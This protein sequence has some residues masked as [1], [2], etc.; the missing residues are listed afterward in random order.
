[1]TRRKYISAMKRKAIILI[2][3]LSIAFLGKINAQE[4]RYGILAGGIFANQKIETEG[5]DIL[6][7][8]YDTQSRFSWELGMM[9]EVPISDG[10]TVQPTLLLSNKGYVYKDSRDD[11]ELTIKSRPVYLSLPIPICGHIMLDDLKFIA[12][13]GPY[14][15]IGLGGKIDSTGN[16]GNFSFA[17]DG[18]IDYGDDDSDDYRP[19][20]LGIVFTGGI[21]IQEFQL[22]LAYELGLKNIAPNGDEDTV[23][24][25]RSLS[26]RGVYF[27]PF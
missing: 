19:L 12:G 9:A 16:S 11:F 10:L 8:D 1:M 23:I 20:D 7:I 13:L 15:S 18:A 3:I 26:L 6:N 4:L 27:L 2:S 24:R 14:A 17:E 21:E 25:N 22:S 5:L